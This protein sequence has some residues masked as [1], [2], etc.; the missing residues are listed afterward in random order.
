M[1][2]KKNAKEQLDD[3]VR[4]VYKQTD[5]H[6]FCLN[7]FNH[8]ASVLLMNRYGLLYTHCDQTD[9]GFSRGSR[10]MSWRDLC[11]VAKTMGVKLKLED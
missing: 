4:E 5:T 1:E 7:G 10:Q 6:V 9:D 2:D 8:H 3:I 11:D